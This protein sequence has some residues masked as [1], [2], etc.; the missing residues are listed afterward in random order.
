MLKIRDKLFR[1]VA[2]RFILIWSAY[3]FIV[4]NIRQQKKE[5]LKQEFNK[6]IR[7]FQLKVISQYR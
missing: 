5:F 4:Q 6:L 2:A 1:F 3:E 7:V